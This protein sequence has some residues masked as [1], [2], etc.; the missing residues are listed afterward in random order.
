LASLQINNNVIN[1]AAER[2]VQARRLYGPDSAFVIGLFEGLDLLLAESDAAPARQQIQDQVVKLEGNPAKAP[3]AGDSRGGDKASSPS[4]PPVADDALAENTWIRG[5]VKWFNNDKG[6]GFIS[7]AADA[8]V[9]VHWRDISSWD[10]SLTQGDE[11]EFMVTK[12]AK[13]FQAINVMKPGGSEGKGSDDKEGEAADDAQAAET[14]QPAETL[15]AAP[16]ADAAGTQTPA[17]QA[18]PAQPPAG[19]QA[20]ASQDV[21]SAPGEGTPAPSESGPS[22]SGPSESGP[23]ESGPS[24]SGPSE[25]G[26]A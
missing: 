19:T 1:A 14:A 23:S 16:A 13:G 2:I 22:E 10:R 12:T 17:A 26:T 18:S 5:A 20:L 21:P 7:T 11:V 8:D 6:Y 9:F 4:A 25:S 3:A 15:A 24:E